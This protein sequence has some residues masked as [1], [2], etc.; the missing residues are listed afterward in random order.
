LKQPRARAGGLFRDQSRH[1]L[2]DQRDDSLT[3][4]PWNVD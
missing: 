2:T 1:E 4:D 3:E